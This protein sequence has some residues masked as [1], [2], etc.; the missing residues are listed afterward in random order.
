MGRHCSGKS[1]E[2]SAVFEWGK[3]GQREPGRF[4]KAKDPRE[5]VGELAPDATYNGRERAILS[6]REKIK[7]LTLE[8]REEENLSNASSRKGGANSLCKNDPEA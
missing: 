5:N 7:H 1:N 8:R 4:S 3:N 6:R 2:Q